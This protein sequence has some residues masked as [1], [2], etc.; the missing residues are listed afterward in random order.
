MTSNTK[1]KRD[2]LALIAAEKAEAEAEAE[3]IAAEEAERIAAEKADAKRIAEC[4]PITQFYP[5]FSFLN[6][7]ETINYILVLLS[8]KVLRP[9]LHGLGIIL[10]KIHPWET[11]DHAVSA[12]MSLEFKTEI[13]F[14]RS[15]ESINASDMILRNATTNLSDSC[16][17]FE[18]IYKYMEKEKDINPII[19]DRTNKTI[20]ALKILL[21]C[22]ADVNEHCF[23]HHNGKLC[24]LHEEICPFFFKG[25]QEW[26]PL[27]YAA[28]FRNIDIVRYLVS[29]G[30]NVNPHPNVELRPLMT[31]LMYAA[32]HGDY[33][34]VKYLVD[35]GANVNTYFI[36]FEVLYQ[37]PPWMHAIKF[38]NIDTLKFLVDNGA[39]VNE[40][41]CTTY[42]VSESNDNLEMIKYLVSI[43]VTFN[44]GV[45]LERAASYG[46][47]ELIKYLVNTNNELLNHHVEIPDYRN[48]RLYYR[49][50]DHAHTYGE[51]ALLE[52]AKNG[53]HH[54]VKYFIGQKVNINARDCYGRTSLS[55]AVLSQARGVGVAEYLL[56]KKAAHVKDTNG[57]TPLVYAIMSQNLY[58]V[59]LLIDNGAEMHDIT[60]EGYTIYVLAR[61]NSLSIFEY[62]K[63]KGMTGRMVLQ[64][65]QN[66]MDR[67]L[68]M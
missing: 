6:D 40:H 17:I 66:I 2:R 21:N 18:S 12:F 32:K 20:V 34:M 37:L 39:N 13:S 7:E 29:C 65:Y 30:A 24:N 54:V 19:I 62:L 48:F 22:G 16:V 64:P 42:A 63:Q 43:G 60:H 61:K 28:Y 44:I 25:E 59:K 49:K 15:G 56:N 46:H 52:A 51:H 50:N 45:V 27:V 31:P 14:N 67:R 26:T 57:E 8:N 68:G 1:R 33:D 35:N 58:M 53:Q 10:F 41:P 9:K 23:Q 4:M 55:L 3:R 11:L 38:G 47:L 36:R 5:V